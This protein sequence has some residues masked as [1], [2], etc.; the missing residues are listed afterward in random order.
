M[1]L[2]SV[3]EMQCVHYLL[4]GFRAHF[5]WFIL[6]CYLFLL[7]LF[8]YLCLKVQA[9][10]CGYVIQLCPVQKEREA[11]REREREKEREREREGG[12][13][14]ERERERKR[15]REREREKKR[16]RGRDGMRERER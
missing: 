8:V 16:D 4:V 12:R 10:C 13:E 15:E 2:V 9:H 11:E 3:N 6:C 7:S 5:L 1:V 14:C